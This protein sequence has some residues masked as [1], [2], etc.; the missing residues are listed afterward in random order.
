MK[1][2]KSK[3]ILNKRTIEILDVKSLQNVRGG[4][5]ANDGTCGPTMSCCALSCNII[6]DFAAK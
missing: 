1:K 2:L 6:P 5:A 4:K 3:L